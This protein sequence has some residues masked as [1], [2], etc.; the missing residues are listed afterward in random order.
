MIGLDAVRNVGN[1]C[2]SLT[3]CSVTI[4]VAVEECGEIVRECGVGS[5]IEVV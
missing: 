5:V 1:W 2:I 4:L 3:V